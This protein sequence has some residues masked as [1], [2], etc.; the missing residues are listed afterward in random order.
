MKALVG[1]AQFTRSCSLIVVTHYLPSAASWQ[2][3]PCTPCI[4]TLV[5]CWPVL[6]ARSEGST[7]MPG[8]SID[9]RGGAFGGNIGDYI[10][11]P[12]LLRFLCL[13]SFLSFSFPFLSFASPPIFGGCWCPCHHHH[14]MA[15][16]AEYCNRF[17]LT[18]RRI[19]LPPSSKLYFCDVVSV[20]INRLREF[21]P[22]P[23]L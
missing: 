13:R 20:P 11:L 2:Q 14:P 1:V 9:P 16:L 22:G 12:H 3:G 5:Q 19:R 10:A 18:A 4:L 21:T 6:E 7:R 23:R 15:R 8:M 17:S